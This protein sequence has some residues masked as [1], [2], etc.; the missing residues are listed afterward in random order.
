VP[1]S[2]LL[3]APGGSAGEWIGTMPRGSTLLLYTDG[4]VEHRHQDIDVGLERLRAVAAE[5]GAHDP[6]RLC[7]AAVDAMVGDDRGDDVA[8]LAVT[9][10]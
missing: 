4:L 9:R 7:N 8:M 6:E 5:V 2:P 1:A 3:G 10:D